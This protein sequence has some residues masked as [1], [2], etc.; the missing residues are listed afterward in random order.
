MLLW[1]WTNYTFSPCCFV[2]MTPFIHYIATEAPSHQSIYNHNNFR[3]EPTNAYFFLVKSISSELL[4]S[5]SAMVKPLPSGLSYAWTVASLLFLHSLKKKCNYKWNCHFN[6]QY[7]LKCSY[8]YKFENKNNRQYRYL[9]NENQA[10][11][12]NELRFDNFILQWE[13]C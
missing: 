7:H 1:R 13:L 11:N 6:R 9:K 4:V 2:Q 3:I 8:Q 10:G 5:L 12:L